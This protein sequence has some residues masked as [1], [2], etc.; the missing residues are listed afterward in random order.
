LSWGSGNRLYSSLGTPYKYYHGI[1]D[2]TEIREDLEFPSFSIEEK[3]YISNE[4]K[5]EIS[6]GME[7][8]EKNGVR[9]QAYCVQSN[10]KSSSGV[11]P[12]SLNFELKSGNKWIVKIVAR[13]SEGKI[14]GI[15]EQS[16]NLDLTEVDNHKP[17]FSVTASEQ[18]NCVSTTDLRVNGSIYDI[19]KTGGQAY[20]INT[21]DYY[22]VPYAKQKTLSLEEISA[23]RKN[24]III[25]TPQS[26]IKKIPYNGLENGYYW[27]Y[28]YLEDDAGN[29]RLSCLTFPFRYYVIERV[30]KFEVVNDNLKITAIAYSDSEKPKYYSNEGQSLSSYPI[31]GDYVNIEYLDT[32][33][34]TWK[35]STF[36]NEKMDQKDN[37]TECTLSLSK[38]DIA[39]SYNL[40]QYIR[41]NVKFANESTSYALHLMHF[42][43]LYVLPAYE[44]GLV[45]CKNKSWIDVAN[46]KQIFCDAPSFCHTMYCVK[47]LSEAPAANASNEEV[48]KL[49]LEWET[50]GV[51]TGIVSNN[52]MYSYTNENLAGVPSGSYYTTICHFA[53]GTVVMTDPVQKP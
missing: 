24:T 47:K 40:N 53:D 41:V 26:G 14:I 45:T 37:A 20:T 15:S 1:T 3:T 18:E 2:P 50:R 28:T 51:E 12:E 39:A 7:Y 22:F 6:L 5:V 43:P 36:V 49:A 21:V 46:G 52:T 31:T 33:T 38:A 17:S 16:E 4:S 25:D 8:T 29:Y 42:K 30:P 48:A 13:N 19:N 27:L 11:Y 34:D 9:Y 10:N 35:D 44:A 32:T 23:F